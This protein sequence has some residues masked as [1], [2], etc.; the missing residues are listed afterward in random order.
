MRA[1]ERRIGA[2]K[3]SLANSSHRGR[4]TGPGRSRRLSIEQLECRR[5]LT[6][7][8]VTNLSD[9]PVTALGQLPGSLRQAIFDA[10]NAPGLDSI[11]FANGGDSGR[12]NLSAGTLRVTDSVSIE[13]P[14]ATALT[15]DAQGTSEVLD[16][17]PPKDAGLRLQIDVV[18]SGLTMTGSKAAPNASAPQNLAITARNANVTIQNS[19]VTRNAFG[20]I[21]LGSGNHS[22]SDSSISDNQEG[23]GVVST[24]ILTVSNSVIK[25]NRATGGALVRS[26]GGI[27]Q[28]GGELTVYDST[29]SDNWTNNFGGGIFAANAKLTINSSTISGNRVDPTGSAQNAASGDIGAGGGVFSGSQL[30]TQIFG[31]DNGQRRDPFSGLNVGPEDLA[32]FTTIVNSTISGNYSFGSGGGVR[33]DSGSTSIRNST[34]TGNSTRVGT[35][36]VFTDNRYSRASIAP[37]RTEVRS[38]I[39]SNN[40]GLDVGFSD[41]VGE[42]PNPF[43]SLGHNVVGT[44]STFFNVQLPSGNTVDA[45]KVTGDQVIGDANPGLGP[46]AENGGPTQTHALLPGSR[47]IDTGIGPSG[48]IDEPLLVDQRGFARQFGT[49]VDVGAFE[50]RRVLTVT[51]SDDEQ[52]S[53]PTDPADLSLREAIS[54]S[55]TNKDV[56]FIVFDPLLRAKPIKLDGG[57]GQLTITAG[58][59]TITGL[60]A[61]DTT[62][63]AMSQSRV[64]RTSSTV[65]LERM[66][67]TGGSSTAVGGAIAATGPGTLTIN[68]TVIDRNAAVQGGGIGATSGDVKLR[69]SDSTISNNTA[70]VQ[71]GGIVTA[72]PL[73]L[74]RSTVSGNSATQNGGGIVSLLLTSPDVFSYV[75]TSTISGN[76]AGDVGGGISNQHGVMLIHNSTITANQAAANRGSGVAS[77]ADPSTTGV[78]VLSSIIAGNIGSD[79]D[80]VAGIGTN[81]LVSS[82]FNIVGTGN[83]TGAFV[84]DSVKKDQIIGTADVGLG[85]LADNGGPTKTH[86]ILSPSSLAYDKGFLIAGDTDQRGKTRFKF[87]TGND[88]GAFEFLPPNIIL[89]GISTSG[90]RVSESGTTAT[91][92]V[93]LDVQPKSDV[94]VL[95]TS[96]DLNEVSVNNPTLVF[97]GTNWNIP[98]T[99][100]LK[101][102]D[103]LVLDGQKMTRMVVS[104]VDATSDPAFANTL[105]FPFFVATTDND[106]PGFTLNKTTA[107]VSESGTTD[108]FAVVLN[109]QPA[110]DVAFFVISQNA[111][112]V[113]ISRETLTF[114]HANWDQPQTITVMG[115][116]DTPSIA[117]GDQPTSIFVTIDIPNSDDTY[118]LVP[119]QTVT[120]TNTDN[121]KAGVTISKTLATVS[122]SGATNK[123][124]VVL[125]S[126]PNSNVVLFVYSNNVDE[127]TVDTVDDI[128]T[129]T[130]TNWNVPQTVT[131]TG[132]NDNPPVRDGDQNTTITIAVNTT[133]SD[134]TFD[135]LTDQYV[136]VTNADDEFSDANPPTIS[137]V[138]DI[139]LEGDTMGGTG[140]DNPAIAALV[141]GVTASDIEDANPSLSIS[142]PSFFSVGETTITFT[143]KDASGNETSSSATV[144]VVDTTPPT[145]A[146]IA[147]QTVDINTATQPI[148]LTFSDL[149]TATDS[150]VLT[151]NSSD[152]VLVPDSNIEIGEADG[153]RI[154]TITPSADKTGSAMISVTV[155]DGSGL[156]ATKTFALNVNQVNVDELDFGDA[157]DSTAPKRYPTLLVNNGARHKIGSLFLGATVDAETDGQSSNNADGDGSDEDGV[158]VVASFIST[159]VATQS[160]YSI[161][162]SGPGKLDAWIDFTGDGDWLDTGEQ[163]LASVSVVE[164]ANLIGFTIPANSKSGSTGARFRLSTAGGL[165]PTGLAGDGEVEDYIAAIVSGMATAKLEIDVPSGDSNALVDG[166]NLVVKQGDVILLQTPL[167]SFGNLDFNGTPLD[168]ILQLAI[169]EA[170]ANKTLVFDGGLG[171]D[172]L[173]LV[174]AGQ[175]LD[176]SQATVT[177]TDVEGIDITGTGNNKLV[178]T[179]DAVKAASSTTDTLEVVSNVGDT[180]TFGKGWMAEKPRFINGQFT[181]IISESTSGGT[182]RV[183]IRNNRPLTN[184]LSS[185]DADLDGKI[186]PLDALRIINELSRRG[187]GAVVVPTKDS[188]V[189]RLYFDVSGDMQFTAL[190]ALRVINAIARIKPRPCC[191]G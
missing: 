61:S 152:Q 60:G 137:A 111:D 141:A 98:Q 91:I 106:G 172:F 158:I 149:V 52:D 87:Q 109:Q 82:G 183:E 142:R 83:A 160:S 22:I 80:S 104:V 53:S 173:K 37:T 66:T 138:N 122:E 71:G 154:I 136:L 150:L 188:E 151:V 74:Y 48:A 139:T 185:F 81:S 50:Q 191:I 21:D 130:S 174:E 108:T 5:L 17:G 162:A 156:A 153:K 148:N 96:Q 166:D 41:L 178:I 182:A 55:N 3:Q 12:L 25:G 131:I 30:N 124:T 93:V 184:P 186:Q 49:A 33:N 143:A 9:G 189:S 46:L 86:A 167:A 107:A 88:V 89:S 70:T 170:V 114:T 67:L 164:G 121:D 102:V 75:G 78:S 51:T 1:R 6:T 2:K 157:M 4:L 27:A 76:T 47:A 110:T 62:I 65:T 92:T 56:D 101:G 123:F 39:I 145:L 14:G 168:D 26:G 125:D 169:L 36:G 35:S 15:I 19:V 8:M 95:V 84:A 28:F 23:G 118:D 59:V 85:P 90:I 113:A 147:D 42:N 127:A 181:H 77:L 163:I 165:T 63:D 128:V 44:G 11:Q 97:T 68:Q 16:I 176:L 140:F 171:K 177:L 45:F 43:V 135:L 54:L 132:V 175:T 99:V 126:K 161:V 94:S 57:L 72:G 64:F 117:D 69:I 105:D 34:I 120:V 24:G 144:T 116:N 32:K 146:T 18:I 129:F 179:I 187:A 103:D 73:T 38:S 133:D 180:I 10:N 79:V 134:D 31:P 29:I 13:G 7:F 40:I 119:E 20:G 100:T 58:P 155:T 159:S 115:V 190:D 112:E